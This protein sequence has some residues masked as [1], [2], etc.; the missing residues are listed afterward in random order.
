MN[1]L[2]LSSFIAF[3][4]LMAD[5]C[6]ANENME[7]RYVGYVLQIPSQPHTILSSGSIDNPLIFLYETSRKGAG[8]SLDDPRI[9]IITMLDDSL[10]KDLAEQ[11]NCDYKLCLC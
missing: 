1:I 11:E 2:Q 9:S 5:V 3:F 4:M 7:I 8:S 10:V 6:L